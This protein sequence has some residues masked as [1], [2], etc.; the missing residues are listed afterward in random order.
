[1]RNDTNPRKYYK[2]LER[3]LPAFSVEDRK[4]VVK[5]I[6]KSVKGECD[7]ERKYSQKS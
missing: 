3:P 5:S 6:M 1:M 4:E 7:C 2:E